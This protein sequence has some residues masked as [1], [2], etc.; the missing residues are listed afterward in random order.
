MSQANTAAGQ[1][2]VDPAVSRAK[3]ER[4]LA[5]YR[6]SAAERR[7]L[8]WWVLSAEFPNVLVAFATT[9]GSAGVVA[10]L[11]ALYPVA[12]IVLARIVLGERP[13]KDFYMWG[14]LALVGAAM[15]SLPEHTFQLMGEKGNRLL[16]GSAYALGAAF[17]WGLGTVFGKWV[18]A[19]VSFPVTSFLRFAW[20]LLGIGVL[21]TLGAWS[22]GMPA[23][24]A[25]EAKRAILYM[26]LVPGVL[27]MYLYYAGL[28]RTKASAA[29][30]AERHHDA[31]F[32]LIG[33]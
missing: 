13:R 20:G 11:S 5:E 30:F 19:R 29:T 18:T 28:K 32:T 6:E 33:G 25:P 1:L 31:P 9:V 12:T 3:F 7:R 4:E 15:V 24:L 27:A 23:V 16:R 2:L 14:V 10:V 22:V 17:C 26:G 8:G 21:M